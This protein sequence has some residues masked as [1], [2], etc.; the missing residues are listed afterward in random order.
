MKKF[1][2]KTLLPILIL[3]ALPLLFFNSILTGKMIFTGDFSGSDLIDLHYPFKYALHNSYTNSRFPLWEPNLSLGFPIAAEGQSG[4]FYPLNILLSF[5]SPESSLQLSIILIFLTSLT[6]M[7]LYCRSLNFSKTESLYA[8]VVFSFS[9]FFITRVKHINLIGVSSYLP[10]L[11]LFIRKFFLKRSF[12]FILLTGIVIALQFLLGHPQMTFYCIFAAVLYAAFEGYQTFRTKKDTSIIPN[13]VLFLFLSFAVAFLLSAVQILPTLEFIQLTSRQEFHILDAG[14]YPF[15]LKNLIGFVSPY[16]AGNPASGSYQANIAYDGI[17][18]ENAVYIGLLGIIFAVFGIYSAIKKPRPPEFLFSIFL[19]LF[20][21]LVMLGASS[22]VFSF[23]WNNIPGFTLFRFPNRFNLFLIF[24]LS[25][26]SAR[27]LQEAVKKI[28]L[29]KAEAK[30]FS[31]SPDDEVKFSWPLDRR[32]TKFLLFAFTVVDLLIFSNSY[33]GYAEKEKLT[34]IP[35]FSEK[36]ASDTEKYRIYSLTQHYQ[37]PYSALGWKNDLAVDTILASR[38]SIPPNNN[39]IYGLPSFNDRGWFEGG[40]SNARRD[41]VEEFLTS[42]NENQVVTGKVL[43]L[44]NVKY[45]IT[46]A[47]YVGI[48]IFEESTLDLGEQFGTKLKL[49]RND[50]V[51]PR[52]YFTPEA[53]VAENEDE[54]FKK[55]TSLEHYGPK[56]V[57]LENKPN[58][59][60]E[61]FTGVIDDFRKDNPV[62]IINYEDQKVEIEADIKTHGFLVLSDSFYPG[63]K[64]RI[65]GTEGKILRANYLVRAVELDPGKH[66]VEFY[67]DPVSFRV[68]LIISLFASGIVVILIVGM[69]MLNQFSIFKNQFTK[70]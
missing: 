51:L 25:I 42:E 8:S 49:F 41:R 18:W 64:V 48:E 62:E 36:I 2:P 39:L 63:W 37:N 23:L 50:Q 38:E 53:L 31:S 6:G 61:E 32:R 19:S 30:T 13:T 15:K 1:K 67:Y 27:G 10:F 70:K 69:K 57:I 9:A 52:I 47:D 33:I 68:G 5:I 24:S 58:I 11:F 12:I 43:G 7:Y 66:K 21:L 65:D 29:K 20:S 22:P 14:A 56:T 16:G 4:P 44:F 17:F 59:L 46:F 26:L 28:P 54:A 55:V 3:L 40:L 35:A 60:P 34:K 45:V